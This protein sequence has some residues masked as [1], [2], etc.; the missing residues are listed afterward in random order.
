MSRSFEVVG[1]IPFVLIGV[2]QDI[3]VSVEADLGCLRTCRPG[4]YAAIQRL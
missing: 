1:P 2:A 4:C 3:A